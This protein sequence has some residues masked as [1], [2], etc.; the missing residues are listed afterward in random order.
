M[1][2]FGAI[3][4]HA[5]VHPGLRTSAACAG[6]QVV[7][8]TCIGDYSARAR[9]EDR[10]TPS[11]SPHPDAHLLQFLAGLVPQISPHS[12]RPSPLIGSGPRFHHVVEARDEIDSMLPPVPA[13]DRVDGCFLVGQGQSGFE[14]RGSATPRSKRSPEM[15]G[16]N[17][18]STLGQRECGF[19][20]SFSLVSPYSSVSKPR[21]DPPHD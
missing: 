14:L 13:I 6:S 4:Q 12:V 1:Y 16:V 11:A 17:P 9:R 18:K 10:L 15:G 8:S 19:R 3:S 2:R 21:G 5:V 7:G 20:E